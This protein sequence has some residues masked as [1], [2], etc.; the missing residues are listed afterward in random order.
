MYTQYIQYAYW[1]SQIY[2]Y[3]THCSNVLS[4]VSSK[5]NIWE[6]QTKYLYT[7]T[8][9]DSQINSINTFIKVVESHDLA[10]PLSK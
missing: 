7:I 9:L 5:T 1:H 10:N 4:N 2:D 8:V 3:L 6:T